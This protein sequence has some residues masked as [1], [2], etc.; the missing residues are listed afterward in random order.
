MRAH[1]RTPLA[2]TSWPSRSRDGHELALVLAAARYDWPRVRDDPPTLCAEQA[3][4]DMVDHYYGDPHGSSLRWE[5]QSAYTRPGTD[6]Y[7]TGHAVTPHAKLSWRSE[8]YVL[9]GP[10]ERR[11][12]IF[13]DRIWVRGP[14]A[15]T[16][17]RAREFAY[18]PLT[19]ERSF[20]GTPPG[21]RDPACLA[22][23]ARNP[24]GRGLYEHPEQAARQLLPNIEDPQQR[25]TSV[26]SRPAPLGF[27]PIP[28]HWAPRREFAGTYDQSWLD[29]R[30][31]L[32]PRDM[33]ERLLC[34]AAP[35]LCATPHLRGGELVVLAGLTAEG[36]LR[37]RLPALQLRASFDF[38]AG[39]EQ[40]AMVL[41][42]IALD[43][44]SRSLTM[45][46]RASAASTSLM[47]LRSIAVEEVPA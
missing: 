25:V 14:Q 37:F 15:L 5:G 36:P 9:V 39:A 32:W 19:Y 22:A 24:I 38:R 44:D 47:T 4:P 8:V 31:P 23:A 45:I 13:G 43:S 35:G 27:G 7:I 12:L 6:I 18:M 29:T 11:A 26:A 3:V 20:G 46:W 10:C 17:S 34:A 33:D 2:V 1:T 30:A 16:P 41:D 21:M 42:A 40:R 28:R